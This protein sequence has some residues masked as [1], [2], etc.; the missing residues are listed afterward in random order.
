MEIRNARIMNVHMRSLMQKQKQKTLRMIDSTIRI[1]TLALAITQ[2][3]YLLASPYSPIFTNIYMS[4]SWIINAQRC[5][6]VSCSGWNKLAFHQAHCAIALVKRNYGLTLNW[7]LGRRKK[8][9]WGKIFY[10]FKKSFSEKLAGSKA[11]KGN[12]D[13]F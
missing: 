12:E 13:N 2:T 1:A 10:S 5:D 9:A 4:F 11:F 3:L 7:S 8:V 6:P